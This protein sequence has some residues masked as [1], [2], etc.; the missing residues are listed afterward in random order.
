MAG[1]TLDQLKAHLNVTISD[2]DTLL[3]DKLATAKAY[4]SGFLTAEVPVD[5]DATPAPVNEAVLKVAAYLYD[6]R[7]S[8][9]QSVPSDFLDLLS[10]SRAWTF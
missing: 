3:T 4:I 7:E 1:I 2:D 8:A 10:D 6:N 5:G 9:A